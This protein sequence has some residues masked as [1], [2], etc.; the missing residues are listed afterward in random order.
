MAIQ[1]H[2]KYR[3]QLTTALEY[4]SVLSGKT[5]DEY[6]WIGVDEIK[7]TSIKTVPLT[8]YNRTST[9]NRYGSLTEVEDEN[10]SLKLQWDRSVPLVVDKGN[11]QEQNMLKTAGKVIRDEMNE[12]VKPELEQK[13]LDM[14]AKNAGQYMTITDDDNGA[15]ILVDLLQIEAALA[16]ARIPKDNRFAAVDANLMPYIRSGLTNLDNVTDKMMFRGIVGRVGT[17]NIIEV[18]HQDMP[19]GCHVLTWWKRAVVDPKTIDETKVITDSEFVSG[20]KI[21]MRFRFGAFV[22]GKYA[23][24][25]V[26]LLA[27]SQRA[28]A[29]AA[30]NARVIN[31][32]GKT[33]KYTVDGT[34]PR[35]S[36]S[37]VTITGSSNIT[38][39]ST[40]A[41]VGSTIKTVVYDASKPYPS[42]VSSTVVAS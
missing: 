33:V 7:L 21:N 20:F 9:G 29:I 1:L 22:I 30:S 38:V 12:Q 34:D 3:K 41:P 13:A 19:S 4:A 11:Y 27:A 42:E 2:D 36:N 10:Q 40:D 26:A 23:M 18:P 37:A 25:V 15:A 39:P 5:S 35:Y 24:G 16:N 6:E 14:W 28:T 31:P 17:L 8:D 32:G